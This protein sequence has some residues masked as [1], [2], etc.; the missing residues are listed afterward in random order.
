MQKLLEEFKDI[1]KG[2]TIEK[3]DVSGDNIKLRMKL[4]LTDESQLFI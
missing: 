3:Y 4:T 2:S 1:I